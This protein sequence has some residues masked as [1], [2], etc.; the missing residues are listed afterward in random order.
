MVEATA[1]KGISTNDRAIDVVE[2]RAQSARETKFVVSNNFKAATEQEV[3]Q[4]ILKSII[5]LIVEE[6]QRGGSF[7]C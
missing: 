2:E 3:K 6:C 4:A 7:S 1:I 5:H